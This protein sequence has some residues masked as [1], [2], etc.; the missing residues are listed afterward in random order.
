MLGIIFLSFGSTTVVAQEISSGTAVSGLYSNVQVNDGDI[1]CQTQAGITPCT[2]QYSVEIAG[3]YSES[4]AIFL[5]N[6][7]LGGKPLVTSGRV[8]VR[9][10]SSNGPIKAGNFV[11]SSETSG[12]GKLADKSGNVL[13]T[14]QEDWTVTDATQ[15]G[16]IV[17]LVNIRPAIVSVS[18]RGNLV[19]TLKEGFLAPTLTPLA[20][21]RY[22]F[23]ILVAMV[24]LILGFVYFGRVARSGVESLGRN[25]MAARTIQLGMIFNLLLTVVIIGGGIALAYAILIL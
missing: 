24:S 14:A 3:V 21:M 19:E 2:S 8:A 13:G 9:V 1:V 10:N 5:E 6:T 7:A 22:V 23:A 20:S 16:K 18:A 12:V 4:P 17:V 15:V 11:T 25:P